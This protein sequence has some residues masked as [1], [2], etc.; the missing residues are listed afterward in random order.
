MAD[1]DASADG[2]L[3][4]NG[5]PRIPAAMAAAVLDCAGGTRHSRYWIAVLDGQRLRQVRLQLGLS[6]ERLAY[7]AGI[8]ATTIGR[9]ERHPHPICHV[10]TLAL[11]ATALG[12][13]PG[14]ITGQPDPG[15]GGNGD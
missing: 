11:L 6:Q 15:Q 9:L 10:R 2:D 12:E 13:H 14:P 3:W 4:A 7:H 1:T 5:Q 8:S